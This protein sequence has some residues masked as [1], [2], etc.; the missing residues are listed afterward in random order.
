MRIRRAG[1]DDLELVTELRLA[2]LADEREEARAALHPSLAGETRTWQDRLHRAG[3][4]HTW[5]AEVAGG[6]RGA[7]GAAIGPDTGT[8][9]G[10][11]S[12]VL[13]DLPPR[14]E[15][16]RCLD[17]RLL[18][19]WVAPA[20]RRAG[21]GA[22][23]VTAC[24]DAADELGIRTF[25]LHATDD[26]R[27]LYES[28]GFVANGAWMERPSLREVAAGGGGRRPPWAAPTTRA[29]LPRP[30]TSGRRR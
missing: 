3:R 1:D 30:R 15:D 21:I 22:A 11:A 10:L 26:G 17:G 24:L 27:P 2:F 19:V 25:S 5:L 6:D 12:L 7:G 23:L 13:H 8:A 20:H 4:I 9:V 28:S 16:H 18:N 29:T 14:P